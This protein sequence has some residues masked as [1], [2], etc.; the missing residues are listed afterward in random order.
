VSTKD[1]HNY[2]YFAIYVIKP[3]QSE[4]NYVIIPCK[5]SKTAIKNEHD[6]ATFTI[7]SYFDRLR[8]HVTCRYEGKWFRVMS[9]LQFYEK[10]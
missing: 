3:L 5:I 2:L 8:T 1:G 7:Q 10:F 4:I 6:Q 9:L